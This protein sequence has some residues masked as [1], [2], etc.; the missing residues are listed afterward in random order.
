LSGLLSWLCGAANGKGAPRTIAGRDNRILWSIVQ[1]N[2]NCRP[3]D[4]NETLTSPKYLADLACSQAADFGAPPHIPL[5]AQ[6]SAFG[7]NSGRLAKGWAKAR[8]RPGTM[9]AASPAHLGAFA[10]G[11]THGR[12]TFIEPL[13]F[14]EQTRSIERFVCGC[15]RP[16]DQAPLR[17]C[18]T[19]THDPCEC[20][21]AGRPGDDEEASR[22]RAARRRWGI[23][24]RAHPRSAAAGDWPCGVRGKCC[25]CTM[26]GEVDMSRSRLVLAA[27]M[28]LLSI[29]L[30]FYPQDHAD[31]AKFCAQL[32]GATVQGH[33][34]CSFSTLEAC[35]AR[36]RHRGGGH[37]YK[38]H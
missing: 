38:L 25:F 8:R 18:G 13:G 36:V 35:R 26:D 34:D 4:D 28:A 10:G 3:Q 30:V 6:F 24:I 11:E 32:R 19:A 31:A 5:G 17:A 14:E 7:S 9:G 22:G 23:R 27:T 15:G 1:S 12:L 21:V 33:P 37:C 29:G 16:L 20:F 2:A